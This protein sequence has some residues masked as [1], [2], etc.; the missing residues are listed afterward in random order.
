M[1][2]SGRD[3]AEKAQGHLY[4]VLICMVLALAF[5]PGQLLAQAGACPANIVVNV[6]SVQNSFDLDEPIPIEVTLEAGESALPGTANFTRFEYLLDCAASDNFEECKAATPSPGNTV[7]LVPGSV[8][9]PDDNCFIDFPGVTVPEVIVT[10]SGL[11]QLDF[12][13]EDG[14]SNAADVVLP[15]SDNATPNVCTVAF[16]VVVTALS[17]DNAT[18]D[19]IEWA[20]FGG[21]DAY[22]LL[23][24]IDDPIEQNSGSTNPVRFDLRNA[25]A[26]FWVTKDFTDNNKQG[27]DVHLRCDAGTVINPDFTGLT[28]PAANGTFDRVGFVVY[29]I[30]SLGAYCEVYEDPVPRGYAPTYLADADPGATYESFGEL[31]DPDDE[32]CFFDGVLGGDFYCDITNTG[33][34]AMFTAYK[35]W[36]VNGTGGSEV[37]EEA[38]ITITCDTEIFEQELDEDADENQVEG[39][40]IPPLQPGGAW[41][42]VGTLGDGEFMTAK[43]DTTEGSASCFATEQLNSSG[44]EAIDDCGKARKIAPG[45]SADCKFIN[46]VFFEGIPTLSQHGM[47]LL[48][49]LMLGMGAITFRRFS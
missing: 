23:D 11:I 40:V 29:N 45:G 42:L 1:N 5:M 49:L 24:G 26:V 47:I 39:T 17:E 21:T 38:D 18:K 16:E 33:E 31:G 13:F 3:R 9:I 10:E 30:P 12:S 48:A 32:G 14:S 8:S 15:L 4:P 34:P 36:I 44:V 2:L 43:V 7:E 19:I 41:R 46:T 27:V 6:A 25:N 28:D 37:V 35:E 22:C 20:G